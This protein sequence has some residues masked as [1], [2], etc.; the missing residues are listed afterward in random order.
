VIKRIFDILLSLVLLIFTS[1]LILASMIAVF[2]QDFHS[3]IYI[4]N[5]VGIHCC[6][7]KM[8]KLR[9]M[10][11]H[12]NNLSINSTSSNDSRITRVGSFIR[13][14]K[15]DE[16]SQFANVLLGNMSV[17]GPRP[18]VAQEVELYTE[19]ELQLLE[20]KPGITDLASIVFSDESEIL[21]NS[22]NPNLD[23]NRI[24]R[25]WKNRLALICMNNSSFLF[26]ISIVFLTFLNALNRKL[27]LKVVVKLL[28]TLKVDPLL[29]EVVS[30]RQPLY[31]YPPIGATAVVKNVYI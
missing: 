8:Y 26:D 20:V 17:V 28:K 14:F 7:F 29:L 3:P 12:T 13:K 27:T 30:R 19:V 16:F 11:V 21:S 4:A 24:I 9:S 2:L 18:N 25:P 10:K 15:I 6:T 31:P 23:Y 22:S 5:R 1:P